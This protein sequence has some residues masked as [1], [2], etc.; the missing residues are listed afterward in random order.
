MK[1]WTMGVCAVLPAVLWGCAGSRVCGHDDATLT[2]AH[3]A[4][5]AAINANDLEGIMAM[6]TD[7]VVFLPPNGERVVGKD[8]VRAWATPYMEAYTIHW[9]KTQL[10]LIENEPWA[11]EQYGYVEHDVAKDGSGTLEDTGKGVIVYHHDADGVWRV[12]RDIW[13]SDLPAG[14]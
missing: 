7:D 13:C 4:Y 1:C 14:E 6:L 2:E 5:N 11:F 3:H 10:E 12:A 9:G 8:A